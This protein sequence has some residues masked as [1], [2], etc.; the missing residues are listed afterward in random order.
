MAR[1][2]DSV[3]AGATL[4]LFAVA[5][6]GRDAVDPFTDQTSS[7]ADLLER[8]CRAWAFPGRYDGSFPASP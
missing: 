5:M 6:S 7:R 1:H 2:A 3:R 4:R 8:R